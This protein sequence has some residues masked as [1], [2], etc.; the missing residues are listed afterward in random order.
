ME[1]ETILELE[2]GR[3][4]IPTVEKKI[5]NKTL[6]FQLETGEVWSICNDFG[7]VENE[8]WENMEH[9]QSMNGTIKDFDDITN[10]AIGKVL[11]EYEP[12]IVKVWIQHN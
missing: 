12:K 11:K 6:A 10:K 5:Y 8:I 4:V 9:F 2:V 3:P 7:T 1:I